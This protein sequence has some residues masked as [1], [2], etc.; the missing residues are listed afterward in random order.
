MENF[1]R[2]LGPSPGPCLF[3]GLGGAPGGGLRQGWRPLGKHAGCAHRPKIA[4]KVAEAGIAQSHTVDVDHGHGEPGRGQQA[5]ERSRF[6]ARM[7]P[8][9]RLAREAV[10][11]DV[12]AASAPPK[13]VDDQLDLL[14]RRQTAAGIE[15]I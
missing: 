5:G 7:G 8:R 15:S 9:D 10:G 3:E 6:D 4:H 2:F 13:P 12:T 11:F 1:H 14:T